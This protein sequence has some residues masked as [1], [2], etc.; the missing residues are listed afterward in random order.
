M[1]EHF[2]SKIQNMTFDIF[3][4]LFVGLF[5]KLLDGVVAY[6]CN[7]VSQPFDKLKV[8]NT[9]DNLTFLLPLCALAKSESR[10]R[11][12]NQRIY[13]S[14][15]F[16]IVVKV[17][18]RI[19]FFYQVWVIQINHDSAHDIWY[20]NI[21]FRVIF[22]RDLHRISILPIILVLFEKWSW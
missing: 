17:L 5:L 16:G 22:L 2:S 8:K 21:I 12:P 11:N 13:Q 3:W 1:W 14:F 9:V 7:P 20:S 19:K 10:S 6:F 15:E 4:A 18:V